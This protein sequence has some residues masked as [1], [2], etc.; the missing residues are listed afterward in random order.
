MHIDCPYCG[1]TIDADSSVINKKLQEHLQRAHA[2]S[3]RRSDSWKKCS[4]CDGRGKTVFGTTCEHC[5]GS[6]I[7]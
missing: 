3:H 7:E 1:K 2:Q 6:G 4:Y 5:S